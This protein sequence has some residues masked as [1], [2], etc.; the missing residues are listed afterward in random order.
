MEPK[1]E[2]LEPA[3]LRCMMSRLFTKN[4]PV[5]QAFLGLPWAPVVCSYCSG[6]FSMWTNTRHVTGECLVA[7]RLFQEYE[8]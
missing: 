4:I 7:N 3:E 5:G 8:P 1:L 2:H 6:V